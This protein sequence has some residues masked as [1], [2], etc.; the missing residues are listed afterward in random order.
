M[1]EHQIC[2]DLLCQDLNGTSNL[3]YFTFT[4]MNVT[5]GRYKNNFVTTYYVREKIK[6]LFGT[7]SESISVNFSTF[8]GHNGTLHTLTAILRPFARGHFLPHLK[9][10]SIQIQSN[11]NSWRSWSTSYTRSKIK[12]CLWSSSIIPLFVIFWSNLF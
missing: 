12:V 3:L 1:T 11:Y 5:I 6:Y 7:K 8:L 2:N 4:L 9:Y 10:K